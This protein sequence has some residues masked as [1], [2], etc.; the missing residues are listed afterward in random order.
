M[1]IINN[2]PDSN[3]TSN[4]SSDSIKICLCKNNLPDCSRS[5]NFNVRVPYQRI[6][7][8]GE[9]FQFSV[10]VVGQRNGAIPSTMRSTVISTKSHL[11]DYQY[12]QQ[13]SNT[14]TKLNYTVFSLPQSV[15]IGLYPEGSPCSRFNRNT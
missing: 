8:P 10:V 1:L 15:D 4:I 9:T 11:L 2:D 12:L 7:Y 14:S 3:T 13:T 5:W 6:V